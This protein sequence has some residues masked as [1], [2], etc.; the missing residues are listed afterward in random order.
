MRCWLCYTGSVIQVEAGIQGVSPG[1]STEKYLRRK[2]QAVRIWGA[3]SVAVLAV[4]A[5]C[6]DMYCIEKI[7]MSINSTSLLLVV[8]LITSCIRQV[9]GMLITLVGLHD[10]AFDC[11]FF[12]DSRVTCMPFLVPEP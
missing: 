4:M 12:E 1:P 9:W 5:Q 3:F 10:T 2:V 11:C 6:F 7:G 8:G